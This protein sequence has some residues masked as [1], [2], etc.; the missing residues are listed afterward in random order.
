M[1]LSFKSSVKD[2]LASGLVF[3]VSIYILFIIVMN[4]IGRP[5][6]LTLFFTTLLLLFI[7]GFFAFF[8]LK[9][10][11]CPILQIY[12]HEIIVSRFKRIKIPT[13]VIHSLKLHHGKAEIIYSLN[14]LTI[15][16]IPLRLK[17]DTP[18]FIIQ[19]GKI[20]KA[21]QGRYYE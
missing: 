10:N 5:L 3:S 13:A 7:S 20:T 12:R 8:F 21:S 1:Y 15:S 18:E 17:I 11:I 16:I 4:Q 14:E 6:S 9:L 2:R 19:D